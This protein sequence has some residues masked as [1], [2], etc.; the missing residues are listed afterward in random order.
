M[1]NTPIEIRKI[2]GSALVPARLWDSLRSEVEGM[3]DRFGASFEPDF[4]P[5]EYF[6]PRTETGFANLAV[7][8][9]SSD[10]AYVV[11]A[12]IPGVNQKAL[13]IE[14]SE[15]AL[16]IKGEKVQET[17]K[18]E[19][20]YVSERSY[21]MFQRTFALPKDVDRKAITATFAHG[22]LT[23]TI[24][25]IAKVETLHKIEVKAA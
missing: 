18:D 21:G 13:D 4:R 14:L 2:Q 25:R 7:D 9:T 10:K 5:L 15:D 12:E 3:F 17:K 8:V 23:V 11:T 6:W 24:P 22:V 1:L 16:V 19:G 20:Y